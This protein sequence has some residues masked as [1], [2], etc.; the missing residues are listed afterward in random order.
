MNCPKADHIERYIKDQ[1]NQAESTEFETHL[2]NCSK[3]NKKVIEAHKNESLLLELHTFDTKDSLAPIT[4]SNDDLYSQ[5]VDTAQMAQKLLGQQYHVIRKV[6]QGASGIV[7]QVLDAVL[8]RQ[9]AVKFLN[10]KHTV[11]NT[12]EDRWREARLIGKLN[13]P[14][15]AQIYHIGEQDEFRFIEK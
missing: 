6:G 13:H 7:F 9:V 14:N 1:L 10:K 11:D 5:T 4:V 8:D 3:C 15:I 2:K 12:R